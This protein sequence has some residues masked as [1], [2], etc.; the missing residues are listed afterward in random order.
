MKRATTII[1]LCLTLLLSSGCSSHKSKLESKL[2]KITKAVETAE[3]I[4]KAL[5]NVENFIDWVQQ[6]KKLK[7]QEKEELRKKAEAEEKRLKETS[8]KTMAK[9]KE[10]GASAVKGAKAAIKHFDPEPHMN[11]NLKKRFEGKEFKPFSDDPND[12]HTK[13]AEVTPT[14]ALEE[15]SK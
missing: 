2:K 14:P 4:D 10:I 12:W 15:E 6:D 8:E 5:T 7:P 3:E 1:T 11:P 9:A 13:P